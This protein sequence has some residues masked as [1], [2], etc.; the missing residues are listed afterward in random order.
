MF[1]FKNKKTNVSQESLDMIR[2]EIDSI[3]S[4]DDKLFLM[5]KLYKHIS[6]IEKAIEEYGKE[7]LNVREVKEQAEL[8][9][10]KENAQDLRQRILDHP[11]QPQRYGLFIKYPKGYEG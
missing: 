6:A 1:F 8:L 5:E 9:R 2:I 4:K 7:K 10:L 11:V 3:E